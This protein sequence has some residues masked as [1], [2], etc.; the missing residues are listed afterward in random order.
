MQYTKYYS[1]GG[2]LGRPFGVVFDSGASGTTPYFQLVSNYQ[3]T[4]GSGQ[5]QTGLISQWNTSGYM[6]DST[7]ETSTGGYIVVDDVLQI[8]IYTYISGQS[9]NTVIQPMATISSFG[10]GY[11]EIYPPTQVSVPTYYQTYGSTVTG[12]PG[13]G[14][15][16]LSS[17]YSTPGGGS[18]NYVFDT[19][20]GYGKPPGG[21]Y[22][23]DAGGYLY[24]AGMLAVAP[25][26]AMTDA[27]GNVALLVPPA[28]GFSNT[29]TVYQQSATN[30]GNTL[31]ST[32]VSGGTYTLNPRMIAQDATGYYEVPD[33]INEASGSSFLSIERLNNSSGSLLTSY[34]TTL[35]TFG[36]AF[37]LF[38][39][40]G[41]DN[42]MFITGMGVSSSVYDPLSFEIGPG[43]SLPWYYFST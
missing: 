12:R 21:Y 38:P 8:A 30:L 32:P 29:Y 3:P 9:P 35:A 18:A 37:S 13:T 11:T 36:P 20:T 19:Y 25:T 41:V 31:W 26:Y 40:A 14:F 10:E 43:S 33:Y 4:P 22:M 42:T 7:V 24:Q 6:F 39:D 34:G 2:T 1:P 28:S 15:L 5:P 27:T 23:T 17:A 16:S